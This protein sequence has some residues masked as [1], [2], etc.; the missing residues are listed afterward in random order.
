[1]SDHGPKG[2]AYLQIWLSYGVSGP[3][4]IPSGR[5]RTNGCGRLKIAILIGRSCIFSSWLHAYFKTLEEHNLSF[6]IVKRTFWLKRSLRFRRPRKAKYQFGVGLP[7]KNE[8]R[9]DLINTYLEEAV[10]AKY[11]KKQQIVFECV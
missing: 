10:L 4:R 8:L 11:K 5:L 3:P 7:A 9:N 2:K 1:M 6:S